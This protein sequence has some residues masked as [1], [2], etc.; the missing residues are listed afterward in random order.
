MNALEEI[1]DQIDELRQV[2]DIGSITHGAILRKPKDCQ[3][4]AEYMSGKLETGPLVV[5]VKRY[6]SSRTRAQNNLMWMWF[7]CIRKHLAEHF[8][9]QYTNDDI[10]DYYV[11]EFLDKQVKQIG[12]KIITKPGQT[13]KLNVT[14]MTEFLSNVEMAAA[15]R[16]ELMLPRPDEY[17][18]AMGA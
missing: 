3:D 1:D 11:D 2:F 8:G 15:E 12:K 5:T 13:S 17:R 4:L 6:R 18:E 14:E 16:L 10:H 9:T 7:G